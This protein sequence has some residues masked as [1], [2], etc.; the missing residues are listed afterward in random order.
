MTRPVLGVTLSIALLG[1]GV[2]CAGD[3]RLRFPRI[4]EVRLRTGSTGSAQ[5]FHNARAARSVLADLL[6]GPERLR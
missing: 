6:V 3:T 1:A 5:A 2:C 4:V